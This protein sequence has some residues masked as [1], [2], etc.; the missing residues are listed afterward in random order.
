MET[1]TGETGPAVTLYEL[2]DDLKKVLA[3]PAPPFLD[4]YEMPPPEF[5]GKEMASA[6]TQFVDQYVQG[7]RDGLLDGSQ[8]HY[9]LAENIATAFTEGSIPKRIAAAE[10]A[11][12]DKAYASLLADHTAVFERI[13]E[14]VAM[15]ARR[16]EVARILMLFA[17]EWGYPLTEDGL[18]AVHNYL[19]RSATSYASLLKG[20]S[21][22]TLRCLRFSNLFGVEALQ[23]F[24]AFDRFLTHLLSSAPIPE[25]GD[26][27]DGQLTRL[28]EY[29]ILRALIRH[30]LVT[31]DTAYLDAG[32]SVAA[33]LWTYM[34]L[35]GNH[36]VVGFDHTQA[37]IDQAAVWYERLLTGEDNRM[38]AAAIIEEKDW[39]NGFFRGLDIKPSVNDMKTKHLQARSIVDF[40]DKGFT[41][42]LDGALGKDGYKNCVAR[43]FVQGWKHGHLYSLGDAL[44]KTERLDAVVY[45][46]SGRAFGPKKINGP[47]FNLGPGAKI[48]E[49]IN[50]N[51]ATSGEGFKAFIVRLRPSRGGEKIPFH[52]DG[53]DM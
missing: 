14:Q 34:Y 26:G 37:K 3:S 19:E 48:L 36:R 15:P 7:D 27:V 9:A 51:M 38:K 33:P 49:S 35:L 30:G 46:Y 11:V 22:V 5:T 20:V 24:F 4:N 28:S 16:T 10:D 44:Q 17:R 50:V 40:G 41:P 13:L 25:D 53:M 39:D 18:L 21:A 2:R 12:V 45:I 23:S 8:T 29:R 31:Q 43:A 6:V 1:T 47:P 42:L 32:C 52:I